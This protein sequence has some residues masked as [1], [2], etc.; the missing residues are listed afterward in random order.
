MAYRIASLLFMPFSKFDFSVSY[1]FAVRPFVRDLLE[2][3]K[4]SAPKVI[5][6]RFFIPA[7]NCAL[8]RL[9]RACFLAA[10]SPKKIPQVVAS[11]VCSNR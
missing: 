8:F 4:K 3:R 9:P 2:A 11:T 5:S 10:R 6:G 7:P 1:V